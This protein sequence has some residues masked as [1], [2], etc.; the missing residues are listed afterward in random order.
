M[1]ER[2]VVREAIL[3]RARQ[4]GASAVQLDAKLALFQQLRT[5]SQRKES[6]SKP[7]SI[8]EMEKKCR[9]AKERLEE[10]SKLVVRDFS[11]L[12]CSWQVH[13]NIPVETTAVP[14]NRLAILLAKELALKAEISLMRQGEITIEGYANFFL[15]L[16]F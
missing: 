13:E 2:Y 7:T 16:C 5:S 12:N 1:N 9:K 14:N 10:A 6:D 11:S 15:N 3:R 8:Y 4:L